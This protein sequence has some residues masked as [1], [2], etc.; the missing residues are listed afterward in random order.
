[1]AAE[2]TVDPS[3]GA[4]S[5]TDRRVLFEGDFFGGAGSPVA[6]YDVHPDGDRFLIARAEGGRRGEIVVWKDWLGELRSLLGAG[7]G[8][9]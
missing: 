6:T 2:L 3:T 9:R 1:M 5:V 4:L 8:G 7:E